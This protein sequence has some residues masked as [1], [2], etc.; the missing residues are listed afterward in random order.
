MST[1]PPDNVSAL[2]YRPEGDDH[3]VLFE[4]GPDGL[5]RPVTAESA[6]VDAHHSEVAASVLGRENYDTLLETIQQYRGKVTKI[7]DKDHRNVIYLAAVPVGVR[8]P[9][10]RRNRVWIP[11]S[12]VER[13][14][15]EVKTTGRTTD[16]RF[17]A[18]F[19]K[20]ASLL[21]GDNTHNP[22]ADI[23]TTGTSSGLVKRTET[24]I[25]CLASSKSPPSA[26]YPLVDTK[27]NEVTINGRKFAFDFTIGGK[28]VSLAAMSPTDKREFLL[29]IQKAAQIAANNPD[30]NMQKFE[31]TFDDDKVKDINIY[32]DDPTKIARTESLSSNEFDGCRNNLNKYST[33][34]YKSTGPAYN[35]PGTPIQGVPR[36]RG[37]QTC[38]LGAS[39]HM[40]THTFGSELEWQQRHLDE[41]HYTDAEV[42]LLNSLLQMKRRILGEDKTPI[43]GRDLDHLINLCRTTND[44]AFSTNVED[45]WNFEAQNDPSEFVQKIASIF[46]ARGELI[47][48]TPPTTLR[49]SA[50]DAISDALGEA[51]AARLQGDHDALP[52]SGE[53]N[54]LI[55]RTQAHTH[56]KNTHP[57]AITPRIIIAGNAYELVQAVVHEGEVFDGRESSRGGHYISYSYSTKTDKWYKCNDAEVSE[58]SDVP[59]L[60][61]ALSTKATN[62]I[63]RQVPVIAEERRVV[64]ETAVKTLHTTKA[65][66]TYKTISPLIVLDQVHKITRG[67]N[68]A[69]LASHPGS[70]GDFIRVLSADN[71]D[72]YKVGAG[73]T[74]EALENL[75]QKI[76]RLPSLS[77]THIPMLK[78]GK[79]WVTLTIVKNDTGGI[80][81]IRY[82]DPKGGEIPQELTALA[83]GLARVMVP[84]VNPQ[85]A[86]IPYPITKVIENE[87][88]KWQEDTFSS[89][90]C[91]ILYINANG[92]ARTKPQPA[93]LTDVRSFL[94]QNHS[95]YA[96]NM[97]YGLDRVPDD[98]PDYVPP[99]RAP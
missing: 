75:G 19:L 78:D 62:L 50:Q 30:E 20:S 9:N 38:W 81:T 6:P 91:N 93:E 63:Y 25:V 31:L 60:M 74:Q 71:E 11:L 3:E 86:P 7:E 1:I 59:G 66:A 51:A 83:G 79:D 87:A 36:R 40:I 68:Q 69:F 53:L 43:T 88:A 41:L 92:A 12:E 61:R 4:E 64:L 8:W 65:D 39:L 46:I 49:K 16:R 84:P 98:R 23:R 29:A 10:T 21:V 13:V 24:E 34:A 58:V 72:P 32:T 97:N 27:T 70:Q 89:A 28:S 26:F 18:N 94:Q 85:A 52:V 45:P 44:P 54:V 33:I 99:Q 15:R 14:A 67:Q 42:N 95:R 55:P 76:V 82:F 96:T 73:A 37:E 35:V 90:E 77:T 5:L 56:D 80:D 57:I 47:N 17:S 48:I 2:F 22:L